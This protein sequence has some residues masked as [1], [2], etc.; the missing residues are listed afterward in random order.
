MKQ[1]PGWFVNI[2]LGGYPCCLMT[3]FT[4]KSTTL[5]AGIGVAVGGM[6]SQPDK[7]DPSSI[8]TK[9]F[10]IFIVSLVFKQHKTGP[11]L[12]LKHHGINS[13]TTCAVANGQQ[14]LPNNSQDSK[15]GWVNNFLAG[16]HFYRPN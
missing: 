4:P 7:N 15:A 6:G 8:A 16:L 1:F 5:A 10:L 9:I 11:Y 13:A 2:S 12:F 3:Q 14:R